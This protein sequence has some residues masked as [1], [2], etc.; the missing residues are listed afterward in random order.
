MSDV[1][2]VAERERRF[3]DGTLLSVRV[4]RVPQSDTYPEG[5]RYGMHYGTHTGDTIIR[6]DNHHGP[7][8]LHL[9]D[10]TF[11]HDI[12]DWTL[13]YDCFRAALP[14]EKRTTL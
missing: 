10:R 14:P 5:Y 1:G 6:L 12:A 2:V 9:G 7:N 4:L 11:V 3:D 8:E 13:I